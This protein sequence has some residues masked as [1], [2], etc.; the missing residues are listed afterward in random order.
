LDNN[1]LVGVGREAA[2][3]L[4]GDITKKQGLF[5]NVNRR[6]GKRKIM[7]KKGPWGACSSGN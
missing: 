3:V 4:G 1:D 5:K 7:G 6:E 2:K